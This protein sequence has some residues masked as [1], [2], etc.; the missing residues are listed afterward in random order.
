[1]I[2]IKVKAFKE[3]DT[4]ELHDVLQLRSEIFVV[5]Q[6]CIYLDVDGKDPK[7][8][9]VI[10][11][12]KGEIVAYARIFRSGDYFEEAGIG[13]VAVKRTERKYGYGKD[14]MKA[15][16]AAVERHFNESVM[17]VSAQLYLERFYHSLGFE[18]IA[19][20]YLEDGIPHIGMVLKN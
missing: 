5:E 8:L 2:Q 15:A 18:Q 11:N 4:K 19:E 7:A 14:I 17:R 1:M 10:G 13:R 9:H 16:I 6:T 3:L 20:G 12:K